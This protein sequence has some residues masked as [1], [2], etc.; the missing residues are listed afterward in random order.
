AEGAC[1][2]PVGSNHGYALAAKLSLSGSDE[3][4]TAVLLLAG[5][6]ETAARD[7]LA[8]LQL[9]AD[10]PET[11]Q[12]NQLGNQATREIDRLAGVVDV[13]TQFSE[14]S[15][16]FPAAL[17]LCNAWASR[18]HCE[19]VSLG[20]VAGSLLTLRAISRTEKFN[21]QMNAAQA[22]EL[23]MEEAVDQDTD[24]AYPPPSHVTYTTRDHQTY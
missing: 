11:Y 19:R 2:A 16:F 22:L 4:C 23:A 7:A 14:P 24:V 20:W 1:A 8:R 6:R 15:R 12:R 17:A 18:F 10:V 13:V 21:R 3:S 5:G 9:V